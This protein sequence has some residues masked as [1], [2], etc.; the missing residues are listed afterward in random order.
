[1]YRMYMTSMRPT[2]QTQIVYMP[3]ALHNMDM[4]LEHPDWRS[5]GAARLI[6]EPVEYIDA[7]IQWIVYRRKYE[8][9]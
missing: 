9:M 6:F 7:H 2:R 8:T 5:T 3:A 1:M 4:F